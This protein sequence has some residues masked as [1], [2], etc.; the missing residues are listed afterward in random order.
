LITQIVE[1]AKIIVSHTS[2]T[3]QKILLDN[4]NLNLATL[5]E[6]RSHI[7]TVLAREVTSEQANN[8]AIID[9]GDGLGLVLY[10]RRQ[11]QW[12]ALTTQVG[13]QQR[14]ASLLTND[15]FQF[16]YFLGVGFGEEV[17][18]WHHHTQ[19]NPPHNRIP[20]FIAPVYLFE[21]VAVYLLLFLLTADRSSL[22]ADPRV[23]LFAGS[24]LFHDFIAQA[25]QTNMNYPTARLNYSFATNRDQLDTQL[26]Q[27][28]NDV[29]RQ[30]A[31]I[32]HDAYKELCI[33]YDQGFS[34]RIAAKIAQKRYSEIKVMGIT[35][36]YSSFLQY[37][38]RDLLDGFAALGC[39]IDLA[40]EP[41]VHHMRTSNFE[42][43]Q[44]YQSLPDIIIC[45]DSLRSNIEP[46]FIPF[47]TWIQDDLTRLVKPKNAP[48]TENDF[49][50]VFASGWQSMY[51]QRPYY[52]NHPIHVLPL[53]FHEGVYFPIDG[54]EQDIDVLYVSHLIDPDLTLEPYRHGRAA[55]KH[56]SRERGWL[57]AGGNEQALTDAMCVVTQTIDRMSMDEILPL[58][59][60]TQSKQAWLRR[61]DIPNM[62][63]ELFDLLSESDGDRARIG[64]DVLSQLK[65]RPMQQLAKAGI[66]FEVYGNNWE[67][68]QDTAPYAR[69][70]APNGDFLNRLHSRTKICINNSAQVSFHMRALEIMASGAFMLSRRIPLANDIMPLTDL[71]DEKTEIAFFDET[72]LVEQVTYYLAQDA[73]RQDMAQAA[74]TKLK[75]AHSYRHRA[76]QL[77]G[78]IQA[79]FCTA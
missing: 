29:S 5:A 42:L 30:Q 55:H 48:L 41:N 77:L 35:S 22:L 4:L 76:E 10:E 25:M 27:A 34:R 32:V 7:L 72:N 74:L 50:S 9:E 37:C 38:T 33:Y 44:I 64:N 51:Q 79:R 1:L 16:V 11:A 57:A 59:D 40:I 63:D 61:L 43:M 69:G 28:L 26:D 54:I 31:I 36:R 8:L 21:A 19:A 73:L 53:G 46:N 56:T 13:S 14:G 78:E 70:C 60:S 71:F 65:L 12:V 67:K 3:N 39:Q 15:T 2:E 47:Y 6:Y 20:N 17:M 68:Y 45:I 75:Q 62:T 49:V 23:F 24:G 52:A 66:S 18:S 58:F